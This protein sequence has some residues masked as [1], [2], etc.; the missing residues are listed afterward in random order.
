MRRCARV[1]SRSNLSAHSAP[2]LRLYSF[3]VAWVSDH[4]PAVPASVMSSAVP[5]PYSV[6]A[7]DVPPP[8]TAD[9]ETEEHSSGQFGSV[10]VTGYAPAPASL[11]QEENEDIFMVC[12]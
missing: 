3:R 4:G 6:L 9:R 1:Q 11:N 7:S 5:P 2:S 10:G 12:I 8:Y